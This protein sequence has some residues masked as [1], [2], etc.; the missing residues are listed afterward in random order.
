MECLPPHETSISSRE[1]SR[2]LS[3]LNLP[4]MASLSS[5][6]P[7]TAVYFVWPSLMAL[8]PA[9]FMLSGVSKSGSPAP[10]PITSLPSAFI[11]LAFA[12]MA[13]VT[14]SSNPASLS[15]SFIILLL[16]EIDY[17]FPNCLNFLSSLRETPGVTKALTSPPNLA[18]SFMKRELTGA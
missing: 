4:I 16:L 2:P 13:S 12:V 15:E 17:S 1:Y 8:M 6:M 3:F 5:L 7:P 11:A 9:S 10:K 18:I 14:D